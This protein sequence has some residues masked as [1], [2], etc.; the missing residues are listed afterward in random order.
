MLSLLLTILMFMFHSF[1]LACALIRECVAF[2]LQNEFDAIKEWGGEEEKWPRCQKNLRQFNK[3]IWW[4]LN[5]R[6]WKIYRIFN[7]FGIFNLLSG[8]QNML[9]KRIIILFLIFCGLTQN[10]ILRKKLF[11]FF[12]LLKA[13]QSAFQ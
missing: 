5:L 9:H 10:K 2:F 11:H 6:I 3:I 8:S 13:K 1:L 7:I 12:V 4:T